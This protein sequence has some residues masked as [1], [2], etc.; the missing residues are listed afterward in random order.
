MKISFEQG[1]KMLMSGHVIGVPTDTV[2]GI[3]AQ[4]GHESALE[5]I[6]AIKHRARN[7][8]LVVQIARL[9]QL[10]SLVKSVPEEFEH[11][12]KFWPGPLTIVFENARPGLSQF[13]RNEKNTIAVRMSDHQLLLRLIGQTGPLAIT[14]AN[15]SGQPALSSAKGVHDTLGKNFPVL[16]GGACKHKLASTII[17][18]MPRGWQLLRNGVLSEENLK[19]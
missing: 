1:R 8:P 7:K 16:D 10:D 19:N 11:F 6:Y 18:L 13:V 14:S 5:K 17:Q 2:Y 12:K 4:I 15:L 3:A 9:E